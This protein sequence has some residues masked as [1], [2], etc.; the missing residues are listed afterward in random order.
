MAVDAAV[1]DGAVGADLGDQAGVDEG[2][3][4]DVAAPPRRREA[5]T[6]PRVPR[7]GRGEV[8]GDLPGRVR[9]QR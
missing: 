2:G 7:R 9:A 5:H 1:V 3:V 4:E 6:L 8:L